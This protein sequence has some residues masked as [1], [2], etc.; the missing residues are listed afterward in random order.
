MAS[1]RSV[2]RSFWIVSTFKDLCNIN[3]QRKNDRLNPV[4]VNDELD[5]GTRRLFKREGGRKEN[6]IEC[7]LQPSEEHLHFIPCMHDD[8]DVK[9]KV[10]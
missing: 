4:I 2:I 3:D 1:S 7:S 5:A 8:D 9:F 6:N 10:S